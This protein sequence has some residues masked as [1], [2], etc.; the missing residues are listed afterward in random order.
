MSLFYLPSEEC[1]SQSD[2]LTISGQEFQHIV[3]VMRLGKDAPIELTDGQGTL[4]KGSIADVQKNHVSIAI[5]E[6]ITKPKPTYKTAV[7]LSLLRTQ[8][9]FEFFLEKATELGVTDILPMITH[10]T[11]S[12]PDQKQLVKKTDRWEKL[13]QAAAKQSKRVWFPKLH[14]VM[15]FH[16]TLSFDAEQKII[17]HEKVSKPI[18][19]LSLSQSV[20][21]C[22]GPEGGFT[23]KEIEQA[24]EQGFMTCS[25]G[26]EILRAETAAIYASS[27]MHLRNQMPDVK[28]Q[29][30]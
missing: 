9:R 3:K 26:S 1:T 11:V 19:Y 14:S 28:N 16:E 12:R 13:I 10:R 2:N 24:Q 5:T 25:L 20:L 22:V 7:A 29:P 18:D 17:P 6:R 15:P 4:I 27:V 30:Y 23:E 8:E 21:F